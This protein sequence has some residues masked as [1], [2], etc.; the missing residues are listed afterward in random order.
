[1]TADKK[2][3]YSSLKSTSVVEGVK[4]WIINQLISGNLKPGDK[5][6]TEA[7]LCTNLGIGRN[8]AREAVKQLEAQGVLYIKR[9]EGTFISDSYDPKLLSPILY[10]LIMQKSSWA[11]FVD[12]RKTIDIGTLFV[13]VEKG[14]SEEG[15]KQLKNALQEL[16][17]TISSKNPDIEKI[18]EDDCNFHNTIVSLTENPQLNT[19]C[20]F[21]NKLTVPSRI[22][23]TR[24]VIASGDLDAYISLHRQ[25]YDIIITGN[26]S[27]IE[28]AVT[29]HYVYWSRK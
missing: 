18:V 1:M 24:S 10:N 3:E 14:I 27:E 20:G 16:E 12:L 13:V 23:T 21:I 11:D 28:N 26:K 7:E 2:L 29:D 9:A 4:D 15:K 25:L 19:I 6:P 22:E 17:S 8:S 5:I